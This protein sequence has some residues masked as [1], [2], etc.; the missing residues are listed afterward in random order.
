M[1]RVDL[2]IVFDERPGFA[3]WFWEVEVDGEYFADGTAPT[4]LA[5][6]YSVFGY[7]VSLASEAPE[8][9]ETP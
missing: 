9:Q 4:Y 1:K 3:D 5:A 8:S 7:L 6:A 2:K